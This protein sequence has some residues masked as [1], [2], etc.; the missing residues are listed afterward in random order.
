MFLKKISFLFLLISAALFSTSFA[1]GL[2]R[3]VN[4][5]EKEVKPTNN[6]EETGKQFEHEKTSDVDERS[7][8]VSFFDYGRYDPA[9]T[10]GRPNF[11]RIPH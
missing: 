11:K 4:I 6:E 7:H 8:G 10:L 9:P 2:S 3:S 5:L 1:S